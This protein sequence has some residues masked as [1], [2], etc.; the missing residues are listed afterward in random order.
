MVN[1]V[2]SMHKTGQDKG[3]EGQSAASIFFF[4]LIGAFSPVLQ[5]ILR[6]FNEMDSIVVKSVQLNWYLSFS[7]VCVWLIKTKKGRPFS[8][9]N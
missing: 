6:S 1:V 3:Q 9:V 8:R 7:L 4:L 2:H 5:S